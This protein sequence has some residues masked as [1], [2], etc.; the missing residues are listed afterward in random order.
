MT[1]PI[2]AG[3]ALSRELRDWDSR[4]GNSAQRLEFGDAGAV[5]GR[6]AVPLVR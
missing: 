6:Q 3:V 5:S 2:L 1:N 4:P